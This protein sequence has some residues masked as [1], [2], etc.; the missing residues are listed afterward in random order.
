MAKSLFVL[1]FST[2]FYNYDELC[3]MSDRELYDLATFEKSTGGDTAE[4]STPAEFQD[5]FNGGS[6]DALFTNIFFVYV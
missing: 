2:S 4:I 6:V 1:G 5:L 3:K